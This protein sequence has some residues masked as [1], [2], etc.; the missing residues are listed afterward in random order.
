MDESQ[1]SGQEDYSAYLEGLSS[2]STA[3]R[4]GSPVN[5][6]RLTSSRKHS[7]VPAITGDRVEE[8][9]LDPVLFSTPYQPFW[10]RWEGMFR[11]LS[12]D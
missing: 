7:R 5:E 9:E 4:R 12:S 1:S 8:V 3:L 10:R 2:C 11:A 6:P